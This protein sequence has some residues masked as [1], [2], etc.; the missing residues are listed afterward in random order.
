MTSR[1]GFNRRRDKRAESLALHQLRD[2]APITTREG[3][4][5]DPREPWPDPA[6]RP[7][8]GNPP[9]ERTP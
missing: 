1:K 5:V 3:L 8:A 4:R 2:D 6:R 7:P 9:S